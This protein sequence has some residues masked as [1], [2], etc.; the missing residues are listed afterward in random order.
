MSHQLDL[1]DRSPVARNQYGQAIDRP[2]RPML[3]AP[4][5][6]TLSSV[7]AAASIT[8]EK[9]RRDMMAIYRAIRSAPDGLID[10]QGQAATGLPGNTYRPRRGR[11]EELGYVVASGARRQTASLRYADV[12]VA[13]R[14]WP[15][16]MTPDTTRE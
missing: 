5:N 3:Q 13:G 11:L 2:A 14:D 16:A 8:G 1:F 10:E 7:E 6:G 4:H 9:V 15:D 12:W